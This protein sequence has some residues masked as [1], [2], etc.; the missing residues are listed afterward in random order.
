MFFG[1]IAI[2]RGRTPMSLNYNSSIGAHAQCIAREVL[3]EV[4]HLANEIS[5][6]CILLKV[7][8][9]LVFGSTISDANFVPDRCERS[10]E[11]ENSNHITFVIS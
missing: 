8:Y 10:C 11:L 6:C 4:S 9:T 5:C 3:Q 7:R 2:F 1:T